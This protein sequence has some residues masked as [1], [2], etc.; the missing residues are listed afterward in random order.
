MSEHP[1]GWSREFDEPIV[2]SGGKKLVYLR[3]AAS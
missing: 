1:S 3:D 2:L